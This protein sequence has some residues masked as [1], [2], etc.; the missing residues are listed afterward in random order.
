MTLLRSLAEAQ[1]RVQSL[2][3]VFVYCYGRCS[4]LYSAYI[5]LYDSAT[6]SCFARA[7]T[8]DLRSGDDI[9]IGRR[10]ECRREMVGST[11]C[12]WSFRGVN[13]LSSSDLLLLRCLNS[14]NGG[15]RNFSAS[16]RLVAPAGAHVS[17][18]LVVCPKHKG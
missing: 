4:S 13:S 18:P 10:L 1:E 3:F 5:M 6:E 16:F 7:V 17:A 12:T 11:S 15:A 2:W 8:E 14:I 9:C